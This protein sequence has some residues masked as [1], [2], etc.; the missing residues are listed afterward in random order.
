MIINI[1]HWCT[2]LLLAHFIFGDITV[3][4]YGWPK[5]DFTT[6]NNAN[7]VTGVTL[8]SSPPSLSLSTPDGEGIDLVKDLL[9]KKNVAIMSCSYTCPVCQKSVPGFLN[10]AKK[11]AD[12]AHFVI[13]YT[14]EAH[15]KDP[16]VSPYRGE[17]WALRYSNIS[18]AMDY[19]SRVENAKYFRKFHDG[20]NG[21]T[22]LVDDITPKTDNPFWCTYGTNPNGGYYLRK[23]DQ[24]VIA[25]QPWINMTMMEIV[26]ETGKPV[27][28]PAIS[29][30]C[31][32]A[33]L[34][35][36]PHEEGMRSKTCKQCLKD[37]KS[38][39]LPHC[40]DVTKD[41]LVEAFCDF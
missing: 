10:L 13:I 6:S 24:S 20:L 3:D 17:P 21:T 4:C 30:E 18:Q 31:H 28:Q 16:V 19:T 2:F 36:C 23:D 5:K 37:Y 9:S 33:C 29:S 11:Y 27:P 1:Y 26:I 14:I 32:D 39:I 25:S 15:P 12:K 40:T 8:N 22:L 41:Q 34:V 35:G 38:E 7:I